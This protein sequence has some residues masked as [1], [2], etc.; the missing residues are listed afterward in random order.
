MLAHGWQNLLPI[1]ETVLPTTSLDELTRFTCRFGVKAPLRVW[2]FTWYDSGAVSPG[3]LLAWACCC[4]LF[5][6]HMMLS[7]DFLCCCCCCCVCV[8]LCVCVCVCV[9]DTLAISMPR[10]LTCFMARW[11]HKT[12]CLERID[13]FVCDAGRGCGLH[14]PL[15]CLTISGSVNFELPLLLYCL[16]S[17]YFLQQSRSAV[18]PWEKSASSAL[19]RVALIL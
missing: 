11:C 13:R 5:V 17:C 3:C 16:G 19:D 1:I 7:V 14:L 12:T 2:L 15:H 8:C 4:L 10:S 6:S 9:C 18:W